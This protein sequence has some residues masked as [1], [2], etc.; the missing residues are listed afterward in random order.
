MDEAT[1][2]TIAIIAGMAL[3]VTGGVALWIETRKRNKAFNARIG[4]LRS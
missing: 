1:L 4:G 2:T 3:M